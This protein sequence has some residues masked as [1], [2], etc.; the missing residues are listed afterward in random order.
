[1]GG[2]FGATPAPAF[3]G[4]TAAHSKL[5]KGMTIEQVAEL[6]LQGVT[7]RDGRVVELD[8]SGSEITCIPAYIGGCSAL[9]EL[10]LNNTKIESLP[11][12][13]GNLQS[14]TGL[15]CGY[16]DSLQTL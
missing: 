7:I 8:L 3:W 12:E 2:G 1:M 6:N 9:T 16:C 5:R 4:S 11:N 13:I 10:N 14:L 15:N